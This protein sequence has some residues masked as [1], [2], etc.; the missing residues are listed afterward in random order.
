MFKPEMDSEILFT[1]SINTA[2][3]PALFLTDSHLFT[4]SIV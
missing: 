3:G 1:Y 4:V 2:T